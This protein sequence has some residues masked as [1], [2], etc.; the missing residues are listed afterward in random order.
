MTF[1]EML[2]QV[3]ILLQRHGRLSYRALTVQFELDDDRLDLLKEELIDIQH[4]PATRT[5]ECW[6]GRVQPARL[7]SP[8]SLNLLN[9]QSGEADQ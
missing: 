1:Y 3:I 6:S 2:E 9:R 7:L 4:I 8:P 5:E